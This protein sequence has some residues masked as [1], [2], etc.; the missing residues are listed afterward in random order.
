MKVF[1]SSTFLDLREYREKVIEALRNF[2]EQYKAM[3]IFGARSE[4][5]KTVS[6][7]EVKNCDVFIGIYAHRYGWVPKNDEYSITHQEYEIAKKENKKVLCYFIEED[8][9]WL[10]KWMDEG[11]EKKKL[12]KFKQKVMEVYTPDYFT[13]SESLIPKISRDLARTMIELGKVQAE[14]FDLFPHPPAPYFAHPYPL[15]ENFTGRNKERQQLTEWLKNDP[16]P[17]FAYVAIGGMGK[18]ALT[19]YW[20]QED[21]IKKGLAPEGIIWWSFYDEESSFEKFLFS[22]IKYASGGKINP[23]TIKSVREKID[24]LYN[25]LYQKRYLIVLD[26][27]ERLLRAYAGL[28]SPYQGDEF[29]KEKDQTFRSCIDPNASWFLKTMVTGYPQSKI[30]F[31]SRLFPKEL[32]G[33]AGYNKIELKSMNPDDA[34][35]FFHLQGVKGTRA[36]IQVACEPYGYHPLKLRLLSGLIL[37]E[38]ENPGDC[39]QSKYCEIG[40]VAPKEHYIM[41]ISYNA[42]D[43]K[44]QNFISSLAAFR[45]PMDYPAIKAISKFKSKK[46]L[47]GALTELVNRGLLFWDKEKN[48]YDLHPIVRSYCYGRLMDKEGVHSQLIDYFNAVPK[49]SKIES[50]DDLSPVIE[51]Y[52]HTVGA[53][54]YDEAW[55]LFYERLNQPTYYQFG[56]YQLRIE[57]MNAMFPNGYDKPKLTKEDALAWTY[58][59]LANSYSLS[60]QPRRAVQVWSIAMPIAK[61]LGEK[62]NYAVGLGNLALQHKVIGDLE[63]AEANLRR[64]IKV[65]QEIDDKDW[66]SENRRWLGQLLAYKCS[67]KE[68]NKELLIAMKYYKKESQSSDICHTYESRSLR[69]LLMDDPTEALRCAQKALEFAKKWEKEE[70]RLEIDYIHVNWLIGASYVAMKKPNEA[71]KPLTFAITEC[72]KINLVELEASILLEMAKLRY[73]QTKSHDPRLAESLKLATE[74]LEIANRCSYILQETDILNFLAEYWLDMGKTDEAI[75]EARLALDRSTQMIDVETGEYVVKKDPKYYYVPGHKKA[76][77]FLEKHFHGEMS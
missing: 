71:E 17:M 62:R 5:P 64:A 34:V 19:W 2:G 37:E 61:K 10:P 20:L 31:T 23:S 11:G 1:I 18:S 70:Y 55:S 48:R 16:R 77:A 58:N 8:Y 57:L 27:L 73:L 28:G 65:D 15:Q 76:Q 51:L 38:K 47:D 7:K 53:G 26:G 40:D 54:R 24:T 13:T 22:T 21:I 35:E 43:K 69:A 50:I 66:E 60:G 49:P 45:T 52:H 41:E 39:S 32:D 68:S 25:L 42:L 59:G 14:D 67:F 9:P 4:E 63:S 36:E 29:K 6:L 3:E 30:L 12:E 33:L 74:A 72:R 46:E 44:K 75:K 56:A